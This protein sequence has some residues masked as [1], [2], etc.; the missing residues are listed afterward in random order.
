MY[1]MP[2]C[3]DPAVFAEIEAEFHGR[4]WG[5]GAVRIDGSE[6]PRKKYWPQADMPRRF[7]EGTI[8]PLSGA[9][10]PDCHY[11]SPSFYPV[12]YPIYYAIIENGPSYQLEWCAVG[13]DRP[14]PVDPRCRLARP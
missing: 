10:R 14:W 3:N 7:C 9:K 12:C 6:V 2:R 8:K 13:L 11:V 4:H 5:F 1:S